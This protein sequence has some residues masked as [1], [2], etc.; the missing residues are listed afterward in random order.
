MRLKLLRVQ[1]VHSVHSC[2]QIE[3]LKISIQSESVICGS[4][5]DSHPLVLADSLLKEVGLALQRNVLHEVKRIFHF[6]DL[7]SKFKGQIKIPTVKMKWI[8]QGY[9]PEV[10]HQD[11]TATMSRDVNLPKKKKYKKNPTIPCQIPAPAE[12]C[13]PQT[14]CIASSGHNSCQ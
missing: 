8:E 1:R 11:Y 6:I 13:Q 3:S 4:G 12:V 5:H 10:S 14:Q 7:E 2:T 9:W